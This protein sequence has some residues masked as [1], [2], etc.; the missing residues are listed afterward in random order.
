MKV[1]IINNRPFDLS[2]EDTE[3]IINTY[4]KPEFPDHQFSVKQTSTES[5]YVYIKYNECFTAVRLS[6]HPSK[7]NYVYHYISPHT[8]I[9]KIVSILRNSINH[10]HENNLK[11][12]LDNL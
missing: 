1:K 11:K 9:S 8:K 6:R 10:M 5:I 2:V 4:I 7:K 3:N 12:I